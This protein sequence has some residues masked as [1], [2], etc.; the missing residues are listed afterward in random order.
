M[1]TLHA[2]CSLRKKLASVSCSSGADRIE[3]AASG[4]DVS[5]L[6]A[7]AGAV[8]NATRALASYWLGAITQYRRHNSSNP[9]STDATSQRLLDTTAKSSRSDVDGLS[10]LAAVAGH[11]SS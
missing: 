7:E 5:R 3:A 8:R 6:S 1:I 2:S 9:P 4:P 10:R 11:T